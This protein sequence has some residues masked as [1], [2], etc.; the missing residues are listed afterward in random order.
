MI[1]S[2][3]GGTGPEGLGLAF[4]FLLAGHDIVIGS[5]SAERA[6]GA[7]DKLT[8]MLA[9]VPADK[10]G[11][12]V[13]KASGLENEPAVAAGDVVIITVPYSGQADILAALRDAIGSKLVVDTVVPVLFAKGKI[14]AIPVDEG[15]A[16]E[17]AQA[18]L[19]D[20]TVVSAFQNLSAETLMDHNET[21]DCSVVVCGGDKEAR[22]SVMHLA[23]DIDGIHAVN[24]GGLANS[25]YVED[26]TT[27]ILNINRIYKSHASVKITGL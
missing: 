18:V 14:T 16:A 6:S 27:L 4:R 15:S 24:G 26:F 25:R 5:R 13:G 21:I 1:L 23:E 9:A 12:N 7:A 8:E 3:I 2:F 17:Q 11:P 19:P 10:L 20:A 22:S